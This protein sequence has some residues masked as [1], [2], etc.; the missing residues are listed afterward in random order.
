M[1][2]EFLTF[3][4]YGQYVWPAFI[5]SFTICISFYIKT[6]R[7]LKELEIVFKKEFKENEN[8]EVSEEKDKVRTGPVVSLAN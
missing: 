8:I 3:G 5:F 7:K 1:N 4:E 6:K 2:L